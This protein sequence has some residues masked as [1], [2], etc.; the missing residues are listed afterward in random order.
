MTAQQPRR[1]SPSKRSNVGRS[2]T[3]SSPLRRGGS[4]RSRK[5]GLERLILD[6]LAQELLGVCGTAVSGFR[7]NPGTRALS[8]LRPF[9]SRADYARQMLDD[10]D[11]VSMI[12]TR[13]QRNL[14][15]FDKDGHPKVIAV[16][17]PAPSYEALC[18]ECGVYERRERLLEL[19]RACR[20]CRRTRDGRLIHLSEIILFTGFPSLMMARMVVAA[21]R[22]FRTC[23]FNALPGRKISE[24]MAD[25][26]TQVELSEREFRQFMHPMRR[27][28]HGFIES[29][30]R[31]LLAARARDLNRKNPGRPRFCG[32]SAF[33]FRD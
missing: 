16:T 28:L 22:F 33:V 11:K 18:R 14:G 24:S 17:G 29:T 31:R 32:V 7:A 4:H 3:R 1:R 23:V 6:R 12:H 20:M 2:R 5:K 25:R 26:T 21:E 8:A 30:D 9:P 10:A 15:Y 13:W 27:T 19:A